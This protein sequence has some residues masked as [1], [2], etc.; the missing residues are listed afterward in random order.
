[1]CVCVCPPTP[2]GTSAEH[3][4][5]QNWRVPLKWL[6]RS[7]HK[8]AFTPT[9][10]LRTCTPCSPHYHPQTP[11]VCAS[12]HCVITIHNLPTPLTC[13]IGPPSPCPSL[14]PPWTNN[15]WS[16]EE[17]NRRLASLFSLF[18]CWSVALFVWTLV[19]RL[20][21]SLQTAQNHIW[22]LNKWL[23]LTMRGLESLSFIVIYHQPAFMPVV[24]TYAHRLT[25]QHTTFI[26]PHK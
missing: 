2:R 17:K 11:S 10:T 26:H 12:F 14:Y 19:C 9:P 3:V 6:T 7:L 20:M 21:Y 25:L 4:P 5:P 8:R 13:P 16:E 23:V 1:M 22:V 24:Q 15:T 18:V